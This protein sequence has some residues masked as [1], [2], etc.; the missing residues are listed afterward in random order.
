VTIYAKPT[1]SNG[2]KKEVFMK[3]Y[4]AYGSNINLKQM[5]FRCPAAQVIG[6]GWLMDYQL[7]FLGVSKGRGG[8]ATV[9][10]YKGRRVPILLWAISPAC[11]DALDTYEGWPTLYRKE[12]LPINGIIWMQNDITAMPMEVT[13]VPSMIYIMNQGHL[14]PPNTSYLDTIVEGYQTVGFHTRYLSEAVRRTQR[15]KKTP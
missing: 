3:V 13:E 7:M 15:M 10:P 2:G 4:A 1:G 12:T 8:V 6:K 11:E 5:A 9:E 14:A